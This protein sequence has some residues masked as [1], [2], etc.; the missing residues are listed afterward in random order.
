MKMLMC[1]I[2]AAV[3]LSAIY[4]G[5]IAYALWE[6]FKNVIKRFW[7]LPWERIVVL[8][9]VLGLVNCPGDAGSQGY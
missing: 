9:R 5:L 2:I 4:L 8:V 6:I 1:I 3:V 7:K